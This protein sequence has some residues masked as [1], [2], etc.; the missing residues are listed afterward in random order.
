MYGYNYDNAILNYLNNGLRKYY[1]FQYLFLFTDNQHVIFEE[2]SNFI[3]AA[4]A[5]SKI[6]FD[7]LY[8]FS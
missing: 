3:C 2:N 7:I 6:H 1:Y 4:A 5:Y 8:D